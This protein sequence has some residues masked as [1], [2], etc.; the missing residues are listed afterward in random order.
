MMELQKLKM[1]TE[2]LPAPSQ[3]LLHYF[4]TF[5]SFVNSQS[6]GNDRTAR[7][8]PVLQLNLNRSFS[9]ATLQFLA[10]SATIP[11]MTKAGLK[12]LRQK[13]EDVKDS[14]FT[15]AI[16]TQ[17]NRHGSQILELHI[18]Q[19]PVILY[20]QRFNARNSSRRRLTPHRCNLPFVLQEC[21]YLHSLFAISSERRSMPDLC[22]SA[23]KR[24]RK[25]CAM[26][27]KNLPSLFAGGFASVSWPG[28]VERLRLE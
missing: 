22:Y 13:V 24:R 20:S 14:R 16:R 18:A 26:E 11:G 7:S 27:E 2:L 6:I 28:L 17:E 8:L 10:S 21:L 9:P 12:T 4:G 3:R 15:A 23:P 19:G 25:K 5:V 1:P